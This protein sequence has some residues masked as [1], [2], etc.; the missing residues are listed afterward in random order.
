L[1]ADVLMTPITQLAPVTRIHQDTPVSR[2]GGQDIRTDAVYVVYTSTEKTLAALR[3]AGGFAIALS[4]PLILVHYRTVPY[5]LP[6]DA[7]AGISPIQSEQ[8]IERLRAEDLDVECRVYL[9]RDDRRAMGLAFKSPSLIVIG[10]RHRWWPTR[11]QTWR[12]ALESS[13]HFVVFVE[14]TANA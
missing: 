7:P 8:F 9:C 11:A 10:G 6:V 3:I 13:G 4:V 5:P 1:V 2:R 14:E 12:R